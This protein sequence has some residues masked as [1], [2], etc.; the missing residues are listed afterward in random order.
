MRQRVSIEV[1]EHVLAQHVA[2]AGGEVTPYR[3]TACRGFFASA[4]EPVF[5]DMDDVRDELR[6]R[7]GKMVSSDR[8]FRLQQ[9]LAA[10]S[11]IAARWPE[12]QSFTVDR[13]MLS[14]LTYDGIQRRFV[15]GRGRKPAR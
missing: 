4:R 13:N 8:A 2:S 15:I 5:V 12:H 14:G 6:M 9:W 1:A 11:F 7:A 10:E 3:V